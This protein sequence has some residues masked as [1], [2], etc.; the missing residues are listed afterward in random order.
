[1]ITS[2]IRMKMNVLKMIWV[3]LQLQEEVWLEEIEDLVHPKELV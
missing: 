3:Y 2:H 1:M